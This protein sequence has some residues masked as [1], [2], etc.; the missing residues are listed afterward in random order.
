MA[1][2][3]LTSKGQVTLPKA[4]RDQLNLTAGD[5]FDVEVT[6]DGVIQFRPVRRSLLSLVGL[7]KPDIQGV[8]LEDMEDAIAAGALG[9]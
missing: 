7:I 5:R 3:T 4:V 1:S 2:T 6:S 9:E 8:T